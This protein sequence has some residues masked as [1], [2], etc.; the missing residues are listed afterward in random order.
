MRLPDKIALLL[1]AAAAVA[2]AFV[3]FNVVGRRAAESVQRT[4]TPAHDFS[5][6]D[7][8]LVTF[9]EEEDEEVQMPASPVSTE[10]RIAAAAERLAAAR[11]AGGEA[12][13][14][15]ADDADMLTADPA[16]LL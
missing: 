11:A 10:A 4:A 2:V 12:A 3:Q 7:H 1:A 16:L 9:S 13:S 15:A 8:G 6:L 14:V 5:G